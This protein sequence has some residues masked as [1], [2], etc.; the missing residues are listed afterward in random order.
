[1]KKKVLYCF[2]RKIRV[3]AKPLF[4]FRSSVDFVSNE[5]FELR[6]FSFFKKCNGVA[7]SALLSLF[8][9]RGKKGSLISQRDTIISSNCKRIFIGPILSY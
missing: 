2:Y 5:K 4:K 9:G 1:M 6:Y 3:N 7:L 8:G